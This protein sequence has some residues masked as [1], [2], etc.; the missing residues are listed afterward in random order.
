MET[1][2]RRSRRVPVEIV[3]EVVI[4]ELAHRITSAGISAGTRKKYQK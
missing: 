2:G 1:D 4:D 3:I